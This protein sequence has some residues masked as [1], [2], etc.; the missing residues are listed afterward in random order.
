MNLVPRLSLVV[1]LSMILVVI[2]A[3]FQSSR[4]LVRKAQD[5]LTIDYNTQM[6]M[7]ESIVLSTSFVESTTGHNFELKRLQGVIGKFSFYPDVAKVSFRDTS[8]AAVFSQDINIPLEAP[9]FFARWCGLEEITITRPV[10]V[11][12]L[13]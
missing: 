6:D 4:H 2:G 7:L 5:K 12:G 1:A 9:L 13:Y 3:A 10:I 11:D 8:D